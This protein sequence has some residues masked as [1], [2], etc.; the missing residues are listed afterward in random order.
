MWILTDVPLRRRPWA[1][2]LLILVNLGAFLIQLSQPQFMSRHM[3]NAHRPDLGQFITYAFLHI[4][5]G[6]L[7]F[8]MLV[9]WMLGNNVNDRLG[10]I[11]YLAF[12][13]AAAVFSGMGFLLSG[14]QA[15]VGASGAIGAVMG[16]YL[17]FFPRSTIRIP[18]GRL[19]FQAPAMH[20]VVLFLV[21]SILMSFIGEL[22]VQQVAYEAHLAGMA[23]GFAIGLLLVRLSLAE[24]R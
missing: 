22:T 23:F 11:G 8:N 18:L 17:V 14:G 1:N 15:I 16:I 24:S 9:L 12:Y 20:F 13:L 3:L 7:I 5:P 4:S 19:S 6:H 2:L 10:H 21:Y